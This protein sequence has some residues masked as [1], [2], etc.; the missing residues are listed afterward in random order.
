MLN[1]GLVFLFAVSYLFVPSFIR[2]YSFLF[3]FIQMKHVLVTVEDENVL[4][5]TTYDNMLETAANAL[6]NEFHKC[7]LKSK[8]NVAA[9]L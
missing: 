4:I 1:I 3:A 5:K 9:R 6:N 2:F 8:L 7:V